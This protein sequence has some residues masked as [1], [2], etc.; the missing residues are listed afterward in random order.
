M[1]HHIISRFKV[2][3]LAPILLGHRYLLAVP[4]Y[5]LCETAVPNF[6]RI[7]SSATKRGLSP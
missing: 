5:L 2:S 4:A 1:I 3:Y 7:T 6:F